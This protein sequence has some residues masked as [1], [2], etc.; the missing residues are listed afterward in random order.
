MKIT[1]PTPQ[2]TDNCYFTLCSAA[3]DP[4]L[5]G[6]THPEAEIV[7]VVEGCFEHVYENVVITISRGD[8]LIIP[9]NTFHLLKSNKKP[10]NKVFVMQ[11]LLNNMNYYRSPKIYKMSDENFSLL[12]IIMLDIRNNTDTMLRCD[13]SDNYRLSKNAICDSTKKLIESWIY[14]ILTQEKS[15]PDFVESK[16]AFIYNQAINYMTEHIENML[17]LNDIASHCHVSPTTLKTTFKLYIGR[18]VIAHFLDLKINYSKELIKNGKPISYISDVFGFSS[19]AYYSQVFKR[20]TGM[21]PL[22]YKKTLIKSKS[23]F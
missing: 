5:T 11:M 20:I 12:N 9:P 1:N 22:Q 8:V 21:S 7:A 16:H 15:I 17:T 2:I 6:H 3:E 14:K 13:G 18:S 4:H 19:Q 23:G 10:G